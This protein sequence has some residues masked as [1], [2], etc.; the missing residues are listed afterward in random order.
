MGAALRGE[1]KTFKQFRMVEEFVFSVTPLFCKRLL[2]KFCVVVEPHKKLLRGNDWQPQPEVRGGLG[3][4]LQDRPDCSS[5]AF[6]F[7]NF[8]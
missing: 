4:A 8:L 2:C 5:V 6:S 1:E 7:Q 3:M